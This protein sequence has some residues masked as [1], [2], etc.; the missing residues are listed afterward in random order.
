MFKFQKNECAEV[1]AENRECFNHLK[2]LL[3]F[4]S[5]AFFSVNYERNVLV[6]LVDLELVDKST[7]AC[8]LENV[9]SS[10]G[11]VYFSDR[12]QQEREEAL[13]DFR[14]G[15]CPVLIATNVA[16]RGLDIDNVKHVVN[17][18]LPSEIHEF[19]HRIGR[20]GRIGHQGKATSFF[21]RGKDDNIARALVKVLSDVSTTLSISTTP[22][23][24]EDMQLVIFPVSN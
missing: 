23:I 9:L 1:I 10:S 17:Y 21:Q 14:K 3:K 8:L 18:D 2:E 22:C 11:C 24:S 20:T 19:V 5:T 13:R 12:Y 4:T 6:I 7:V 15:S 16:A